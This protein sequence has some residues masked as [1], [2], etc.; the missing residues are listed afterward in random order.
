MS[1]SRLHIRAFTDTSKAE[2]ASS[3]TIS[4]GRSAIARAIQIRCRCPPENSC[5]RRSAISGSS[6]TCTSRSWT[7]A[8]MSPV[9]PQARNGS[10]IAS[11][12][13]CLGLRLA[14]G[15]WN[16]ICAARRA[17]LRGSPRSD[18]ISCPARMTCPEVTGDRPRIARPIV[19]FPL[20]DSPTS[21]SVSPER[22]SKV[23]PL[24][25][26]LLPLEIPR[27]LDR[28]RYL[29]FRSRTLRIVF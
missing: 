26:W 7:T 29:T 5:G 1:S 8:L 12:M 18:V 9:S 17:C 25:A 27:K 13:R 22:R 4:D 23:T 16:T 10:L 19:D 2:T 15:S 20:P 11:R 3:A 6:P 24:T 14:A 21:A 28:E